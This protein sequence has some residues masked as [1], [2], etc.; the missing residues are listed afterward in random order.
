MYDTKP[1]LRFYFRHK[2]EPLSIANYSWNES[3]FKWVSV[4]TRNF[5]AWLER[6]SIIIWLTLC[7]ILFV[8]KFHYFVE[9]S[10]P[11]LRHRWDCSFPISSRLCAQKLIAK[12]ERISSL[13]W[14][15]LKSVWF[16]CI[17][18]CRAWLNSMIVHGNS[19][20]VTNSTFD[21]IHS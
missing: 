12:W 16:M 21:Y 9:C 7:S 11:K 17:R 2:L 10:T 5:N 6:F 3:H 4:K 20:S 15:I 1:S 14:C 13:N 19:R 8:I 18:R